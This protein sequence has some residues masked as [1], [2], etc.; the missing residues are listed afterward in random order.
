LRDEQ[1]TVGQ[2]RKAVAEFV[3]QRD[4]Q[5]FHDPKNLAMSISIEA[6]EL[7]EHFQ[8]LRNDQISEVIDCPD[9]LLQVK[10]ELADVMCFLLAFANTVGID[11]SEAVRD[12]L[13]KNAEKYPADRFK[14]RFK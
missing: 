4:W 14:G 3:D 5:Q 1:T 6:S 2:L 11:I 10:E 13:V 8:W 12:K 9:S 7:M